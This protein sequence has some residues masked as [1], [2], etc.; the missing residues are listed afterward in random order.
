MKKIFLVLISGALTF[1]LNAQVRFSG[2]DYIKVKHVQISD[3]PAQNTLKGNRIEPPRATKSQNSSEVLGSTYYDLQTNS[4]VQDR[5][6]MNSNGDISATWTASEENSTSFSDRGT[7]YSHFDPNTNTWTLS[8]DYPRIEQER[9]GW[10]SMLYDGNGGELIV[11]HTTTSALNLK[12]NKRSAIGTGNWTQKD[13]SST[14]LWWSRA[15]M[16]GTDGNTLHII[17]VTNDT[18]KVANFQNMYHAVVYYRS[19]DGGSTFDMVDVILPGIDSAAYGQSGTNFL[20]S[21]MANDAYAIAAKGNV[22]AFAIFNRFND[23]IL[24]KSTDNGTNWTKTIVNDFPYNNYYQMDNFCDSSHRHITSDNAGAILIDANNMV[25]LTWGRA[26]VRNNEV[27]DDGFYYLTGFTDSLGYWNESMGANNPSTCGFFVDKNNNGIIDVGAVGDYYQDGWLSYPNMSLGSDGSI[28]MAYSGLSE[29]TVWASDFSTGMRHIYVVRSTDG[30]MSWSD[31]YDLTPEEPDLSENV[32]PDMVNT[33]DGH[34]RLIYQ[35]DWHPS[36]FVSSI[37]ASPS[38]YTQQTQATLNDIIYLEVDT[39]LTIGIEKVISGVGETG[40]FP[41][42]TEGQV[43][44]SI[45]VYK[46]IDVNVNVTNMSGQVV[47]TYR[48]SALKVGKNQVGMDLSSLTSGMYFINI[49]AGESLITEK[50][51]LK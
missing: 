23:I 49:Q 32:Y 17:A 45:R 18:N 29:D 10:S 44:L 1:S 30:G 51:I 31:P 37:G 46:D 4:A 43:I 20:K 50:L 5:I 21:T 22:V 19:Q 33:T 6:V 28:W 34:L 15:A 35:H 42:P 11:S 16:G 40:V 41:N 36:V 48:R 7:G 13:V 26:T 24:M 9:C 47:H 39:S 38:N 27:V 8:P 3:L 12:L 2:T 14:N 25:H